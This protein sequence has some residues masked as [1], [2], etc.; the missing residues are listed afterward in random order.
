MTKYKSIPEPLNDTSD[1]EE[2]QS[3]TDSDYEFRKWCGVRRSTI[4]FGF[5]VISYCSYLILGGYV[6]S[7]LETS[8]V[9]NMKRQTRMVKETFL[10]RNPH[11]NRE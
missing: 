6:M 3:D 8:Q 11:I 1:T 4:L 7:I 5:Y 2:E 10:A 9:E